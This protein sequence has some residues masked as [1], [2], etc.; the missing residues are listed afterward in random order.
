MVEEMGLNFG[1]THAEYIVS[2]RRFFLVEVAARGGGAGISSH[3]VP[4]MS[5]IE[6][7]EL[8]IRMS[9]REK[10]DALAPFARTYAFAMISFLNFQTGVVEAVHGLDKVREL[11]GLLHISLN[12]A[13]GQRLDPPRDGS[14][15]QG[16]FI[17]A[18]QSLEELQALSQKIHRE[19]RV[20]YA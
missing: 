19:L 6:T 3:V 2:E 20:T 12:I 14:S 11:P 13:P 18:A 4:A 7:N 5:G 9:L 16:S 1:I 15:R 10:I 8:L 17:A